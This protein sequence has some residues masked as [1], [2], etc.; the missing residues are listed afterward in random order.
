MGVVASDGRRYAFPNNS[1]LSSG[2]GAFAPRRAAVVSQL[3]CLRSGSKLRVSVLGGSSRVFAIAAPS[4]PPVFAP[5]GR[6]VYASGTVIRFLDG[7]T[8]HARGL[9]KAARIAFLAV[10]PGKPLAVAAAV[11]WGGTHEALYVI[12]KGRSRRVP[13]SFDA[14]SERPQPVW[15]PR[16][17]RFAFVRAGSYRGGDIYLSDRQASKPIRL[18]HSTRAL[19]PL[20]SP[21][22]T[23]IAFTQRYGFKPGRRNGIPEVYVSDLHGRQ[24]RLTHTRPLPPPTHGI[25]GSYTPPGSRAGAW[26]PDGRWIAIVSNGALAVVPAA[27]GAARILRRFQLPID[28]IG[29]GPLAWPPR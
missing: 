24:R 12:S 16:G 17:D 25:P 15:S 1:F 23:K 28:Q 13:I 5:D 8:L 7:A 10:A 2:R 4:A 14:L 3:C 22:G 18:T 6:V 11:V 20:W 19:D 29:L 26:S 21:E 9:P 27:G